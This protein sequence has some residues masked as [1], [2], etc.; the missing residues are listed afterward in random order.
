MEGGRKKHHVAMR[1]E[2][3]PMWEEIEKKSGVQLYMYVELQWSTRLVRSTAFDIL[4]L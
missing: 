2:S 1:K 3:L 4:L